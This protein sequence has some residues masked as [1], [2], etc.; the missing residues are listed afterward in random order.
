M[1]TIKITVL[2]TVINEK[3]AKEYGAPD[4]DYRCDEHQPGEVYYYRKGATPPGLCAGAWTAFEKYAFAMAFGVDCFWP[5][6]CKPGVAVVTCND[7]LRPT[8]FKLEV[9][10][11]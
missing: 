4:L 10:E 8:A 11:E 3:L 9:M 7:G 5:N 6:W 1:R 2:E